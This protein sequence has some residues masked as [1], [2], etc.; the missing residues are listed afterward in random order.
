MAQGVLI[1]DRF[2]LDLTRGS[3][4]VGEQDLVLR[5]KAFELLCF[6]AQNAGRLVSKQ[7]LNDAVWPDVIV[8]DDSIV[9]CIRELRSKL[10]D[11]DRSLIKTVPRRGYL[12]DA[13]ASAPAPQQAAESVLASPPRPSWHHHVNTIPVRKLGRWAAVA[14]VLL[15]VLWGVNHGVGWAVKLAAEPKPASPQANGQFDGI[16]RIEFANNEFCIQRSRTVLWSISQGVVKGSDAS[17]LGG[18]VSSTG[19][20]QVAWPSLADPTVAN[21]GSAKLQGDRGEG[22]WDGQRACAGAMTLTR[23]ART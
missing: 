8:S 11:G 15:T 23:M 9:Q 21:I 20:L 18:T 1:F 16:W 2:S 13:T 17:K 6:L 14:V 22:K 10:G 4:R 19:E 12:L 7:E 3:A 5:P